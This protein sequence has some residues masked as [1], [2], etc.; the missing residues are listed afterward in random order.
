MC[1]KFLGERSRLR[2]MGRALCIELA[3]L[4]LLVGPPASLYF[5]PE[6]PT[7][8][9][10]ILIGGPSMQ[11]GIGTMAII[12]MHHGDPVRRFDII[13]LQNRRMHRIVG[14]PGDTF[15]V[16]RCHAHGIDQTGRPWREPSTI[17]RLCTP[18]SRG[19]IHVA[20]SHYL[21]MADNREFHSITVLTRADMRGTL[22]F[23]VISWGGRFHHL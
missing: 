14:M 5:V 8:Y 11:P 7:G 23:P 1:R 4:L 16:T 19:P 17:V 20:P 15:L 21:M 2:R 9:Y 10:L 22:V 13:Q 6:N 12:V 3:V 18:F